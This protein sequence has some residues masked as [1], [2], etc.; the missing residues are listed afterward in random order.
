MSALLKESR[1][2]ERKSEI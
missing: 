2:N 1:L